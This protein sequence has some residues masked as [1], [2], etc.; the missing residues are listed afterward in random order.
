M[1]IEDIIIDYLE[2]NIGVLIYAEYPK[3]PPSKFIVL[4]RITGGRKDLLNA[5]TISFMCYAESKHEAAELQDLLKELLYEIDQE[6]TISGVRLGGESDDI[7][8]T[9]KRYCYEAIFNLFY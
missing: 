9:N 1:I 2:K 5:S 8:T 4:Q 3:S 6:P 7:D